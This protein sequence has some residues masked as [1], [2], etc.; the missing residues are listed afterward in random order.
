M[1]VTIDP[2]VIFANLFCFGQRQITISQI[3][4]IAEKLKS[5][6]YL[7]VSMDSLSDAIG[8]HPDMFEWKVISGKPLITIPN[9]AQNLYFPKDFVEDRFNKRIPADIKEK[10]LKIIQEAVTD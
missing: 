1:S 2:E 4:G 10:F 3:V 8:R 6:I 9:P 5:T 7:D